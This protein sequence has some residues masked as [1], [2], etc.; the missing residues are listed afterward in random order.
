MWRILVGFIVTLSLAAQV[1][2]DTDPNLARG[3]DPAKAFQVGDVDAVNVFN[4]NLLVTIPIG[5]AYPLA[6]GFSYRLALTFNS[7]PWNFNED[8]DANNT[9]HSV[10]LQN[11]RNNAGF[12][13]TLSLGRV[14]RPGQKGINDS[15]GFMYVAPDGS[16]HE[17]F[18]TLH[19]NEPSDGSHLFTRD[20]SYLRMVVSGSPATGYEVDSPDGQVRFF[21]ADGELTRLQD[22]F[23]N[24]VS[25]DT[26]SDPMKWIITDSQ[27]RTQT[28]QFEP[29][30][31]SFKRIKTV[32]LQAFD[33]ALATYGF[34]YAAAP[35]AIAKACPD[36][37]G[38]HTL[39]VD[40]L[41][42]VTLPLATLPSG[43]PAAASWE[44][45]YYTDSPTSPGASCKQPGSLKSLVLPTGGM[46]AWTYQGYHLPVTLTQKFPLQ[47]SNGVAVRTLYDAG[48][49]SL[50][51]WTYTPQLDDV[52]VPNAHQLVNTVV[53]PLGF[54]TANYFS[55]ARS[56]GPGAWAL[57]EYGL[58]LT[59]A[60]SDA[61]GARF[62]ST[63]V[64]DASGAVLR[65]T[66]VRYEADADIHD[67][68]L[69]SGDVP[70][71]NQRLA[72]MRTVHSADVGRYVDIDNAGFDGFGHYGSVSTSGSFA[73]AAL[74]TEQTGWTPQ[75]R[76]WL[77]DQYNY[78]QQQEGNAVDRQDFVF[79][80]DTGFLRCKRVLRN[81]AGMDPLDALVIYSQCGE[82][83]APPCDA[84]HPA[85]E[86]VTEAWYGGDTQ[87]LRT[88][89]ICS[90][91]PPSP[92]YSLSHQYTAGVL[93]LTSAGGV[94]AVDL[95][96]D[97]SSGLAQS[98]RDASGRPTVFTYD[99]LGRV[100]SVTPRGE[101]TTSISYR[102][103]SP[104]TPIGPTWSTTSAELVV[105]PAAAPLSHE[106]WSYD[107]FG[108]IIQDQISM[109]G[110][111][112]GA[113]TWSAQVT[114]YNA[115]GWKIF[116][117][118]RGNPT[119]GT[120][121]AAYDPFG[122]AGSITSAD[123]KTTILA[124]QG[125]EVLKRTSKVWSAEQQE[126][127]PST[128][129][130]EYDVLGRL[131][132]VTEPNATRTR[133]TYDAGGRLASV[134]GN[135]GGR[136]NAQG[137][138]FRYDG[139]GFLTYENHPELGQAVTYQ[140]DPRGNV[141]SKTSA[142]GT[143]F[144]RYDG[145][146]RLTDVSSSQALLRQLTY[147]NGHLSRASGFNDRVTGICTR[148]EVR[149]DLSYF[150]DTGK[151]D[152]ELT[153]LLAQEPTSSLLQQWSQFYQYDGAGSLTRVTYPC[154]S[155]GSADCG[156]APR[157][158]QT[159]Y[160]M[161]R[162]TLVAFQSGVA[163]EIGAAMTYNPNGTPYSIAHGNGVTFYQ[164]Q[165]INGMPRPRTLGAT[166]GTGKWIWPSEDYWYDSSGNIRQVGEKLFG[167]DANSRITSALLPPTLAP[168]NYSP[169]RSYV[170][171]VFGNLTRVN[172]GTDVNSISSYIDYS[173]T[174]ST[175][176]LTGASYDGAGNLTQ[177][178]GSYGWDVL[179]QLASVETSTEKWM[180][181]YDAQGERI[182]ASRQGPT[183]EDI[184]ELRGFG[185][186]LLTAFTS[187]GG[188]LTFEDYL[189]REGKL[190]AAGF[191]DGR[192]MNFDLDH[193]GNVRLET[194]GSGKY[195]YREFW[196]YGEVSTT[197]GTMGAAD[198]ERMKFAGHQRD[199]VDSASVADQVD[200]M[201][202]RYYKPLLGRF[203]SVDPHLP[204]GVPSS[205]GAW[206]RYTYALD[207]AVR[208]R[209]PDGREPQS[210]TQSHVPPPSE[211]TFKHPSLL[212][213]VLKYD[214]RIPV[215]KD[216]VGVKVDLGSNQSAAPIL[217]KDG[218]GANVNRTLSVTF[219]FGFAE[220]TFGINTST[221]LYTATP[222]KAKQAL[223]SPEGFARA[224]GTT[225]MSS[226]SVFFMATD[227][228]FSLPLLGLELNGSTCSE[229]GTRGCGEAP[230][231]ASPES[232]EKP[233]APPPG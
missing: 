195:R 148:Y 138:A 114:V 21:N 231:S 177:Y 15:F 201:H 107:G 92:I 89:S 127:L 141:V 18:N 178:Q 76:V 159:T 81:G 4:G 70:K 125:T 30:T 3:F 137:R 49:S 12:G 109:P 6:P 98:S 22:V 126:E 26:T 233:P 2:A 57:V 176:H 48:G 190:I 130:E 147:A 103:A 78:K 161:G 122:R 14:E 60:V 202:A 64:M 51:Q 73:F 79:D 80:S 224:A 179:G 135:V 52:N 166:D 84:G 207:N 145:A 151:L 7:N 102:D 211:V 208:L 66:Y 43:A 197:A 210:P 146:G 230:A 172:L 40:L 212:E 144:S 29:A 23:G 193:I 82:A 54:T 180:N 68:E 223:S 134:L 185:N 215:G 191:S 77:L 113:E 65:S 37:S 162:P 47:I 221:T 117:S 156:S 169:F 83:G 218:T 95:T 39:S 97:P 206:N 44:P 124:Y 118:E 61:T 13:W 72:S 55:V 222:D 17:F 131:R 170:Y 229:P 56:D 158:S 87:V 25:L 69:S 101:A 105:G 198:S 228:K 90:T 106:I 110:G 182:W 75:A 88:D 112:P 67:E 175:N 85:G 188:A 149:Q 108:R 152:S 16:E 181:V 9:C 58:P 164:T 20:G 163:S 62:L 19:G 214:L 187:V 142:A 28:V 115:M 204:K 33:G 167:Y 227:S 27:N 119:N 93:S 132:Q 225:P 120:S 216:E 153:T 5:S 32:T 173:T 104:P 155:G 220:V 53:D 1:G 203:L 116:E 121:Y 45:D 94:N 31:S 99:L 46:V 150:A 143:V 184:F 183:Q 154:T 186:Q 217:T 205:P 63:Q 111:S 42:A 8:C 86:P 165:D 59:H 34:T 74:R 136:A 232:G 160:S 96:V 139:R 100:T 196:P 192:A 209:D 11:P 174:P 123:A 194:D 50:G 38:V 140:Y 199:H 168:P 24:F 91:L 213:A 10:A 219:S 157:Y 128:T 36:A 41:K 226:N 35:V 189:Y 133:Y 129:K 171:D 200:Y 71:L